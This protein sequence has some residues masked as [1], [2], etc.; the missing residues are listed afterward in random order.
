MNVQE[1]IK[2]EFREV[3]YPGDDHIA[4]HE[5]AEC[6]QIRDDFRGKSAQTFTNAVLERR[7]DSLPLLSPSAFHYFVSAY[8]AYSLKH[9]DSTVA[10]FTRQG[11]G[12]E[13]FDDFYLE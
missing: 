2:L 4:L 7:Y 13:G 12:E 9:P 3:S 11:L 6:R 8:M 5:C 1:F 10:F